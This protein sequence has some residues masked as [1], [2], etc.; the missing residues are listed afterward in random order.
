VKKELKHD[1]L[2]SIPSPSLI[3]GPDR[4]QR[5]KNGNARFAVIFTIP[6]RA[7]PTGISLRAHRLKN[8]PTLGS[9]QCAGLPKICLKRNNGR[10]GFSRFSIKYFA[11]LRLVESSDTHSRREGSGVLTPLSPSIDFSPILSHN[12][13]MCIGKK[14]L[15]LLTA[16]F[17][18]LFFTP[19]NAQT[20]PGIPAQYGETIYRF[21]EKSPNQIFIIGISHRDALT[22]LNGDNTSRVQAEIYRIGEWLMH[23]QQVDLILPEGF[24]KSPSANIEEKKVNTPE[25]GRSCT[26]IDTE[27]LEKRLSDNK[28]YVNAEMLLKEN[29]S[30]RL[31]QIEDENLYKAVTNHL[32]KLAR[33]R[34]DSTDYPRLNSEIEF[35]QE[36]RAAAMLQKIPQ[37]V[38]DEFQQGNIRSK[39]AIFTIGL[40]HLHNII[41]YLNEKGI[42]IHPPP[43][44]SN[45]N[46]GYTAELNLQKEN[47]GVSVIVPQTLANDQKTLEITKLNEIVKS[48]QTNPAPRS[49]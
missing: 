28:I 14:V 20:I 39:K 17:S 2:R 12:L 37:I 48:I 1:A 49:H 40:F 45:G 23:N 4:R 41:A 38:N 19:L 21:N 6:R 3:S 44:I 29:H 18:L 32:L 8:F 25:R 15:F 42:K 33:S 5:W 31:R 13:G 27:S 10:F 22:C 46:G 43:S 30:L 36:K 35:L 47:F 24:F 11:A 9:A 16:F 7:I 34:E 26:P